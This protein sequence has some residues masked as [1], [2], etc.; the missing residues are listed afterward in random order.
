MKNP[1]TILAVLAGLSILAMKVSLIDG[2]GQEH[3]ALTGVM[4]GAIFTWIFLKNPERST[5][6]GFL[7]L[8]SVLMLLI[9]GAVA[10]TETTGTLLLTIFWVTLF[11]AMSWWHARVYQKERAAVQQQQADPAD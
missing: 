5:T 3:K 2:P 1:R 6:R 8:L 7:I 11:I 4:Y 10:L 9:P